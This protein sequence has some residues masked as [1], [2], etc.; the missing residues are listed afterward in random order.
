MRPRAGDKLRAAD[1]L[2]RSWESLT[3]PSRVLTFSVVPTDPHRSI[4][5]LRCGRRLASETRIR[6]TRADNTTHRLKN[7][8]RNSPERLRSLLLGLAAERVAYFDFLRSF[9]G[10]PGNPLRESRRTCL[11]GDLVTRNSLASL[12]LE[13]PPEDGHPMRPRE[14]PICDLCSRLVAT[15]THRSLDS[16]ARRLRDFDRRFVPPPHHACAYTR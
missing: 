15:S 4:H 10:R 2:R 11:V 16:R 8:A 5:Y 7:A 13:H 1:P 9:R 12:S 14:M 3:L 6:R